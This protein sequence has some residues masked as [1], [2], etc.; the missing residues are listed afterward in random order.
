MGSDAAREDQAL[1]EPQGLVSDESLAVLLQD[2]LERRR[3]R[4]VSDLAGLGRPHTALPLRSADPD[5]VGIL[6]DVGPSK[7]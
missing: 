7:G 5:H 6:V 4:D 2:R 3:E 1:G